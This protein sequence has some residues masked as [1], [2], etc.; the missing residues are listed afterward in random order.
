M[1]IGASSG[2]RAYCRMTTADRRGADN[3]R[4]CVTEGHPLAWDHPDI[5]YVFNERGFPDLDDAAL[6]KGLVAAVNALRAQGRI[7]AYH[8]RSD[9]GLWAAV[10]EMAFAGKQGV[11]LNVDILVTEGDGGGRHYWRGVT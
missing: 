8:D 4:D 6:L 7:L 2:A 11:S 5:A 10:C 3:C 1:G 9:G